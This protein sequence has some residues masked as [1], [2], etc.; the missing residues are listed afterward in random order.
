M[1]ETVTGAEMPTP[2]KKEERIDKT[3]RRGY[4]RPEKE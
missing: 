3:P 4:L 1:A 2:R